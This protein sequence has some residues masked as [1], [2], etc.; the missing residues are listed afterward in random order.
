MKYKTFK[1]IVYS[2]CFLSIFAVNLQSKLYTQ[3]TVAGLNIQ[4]PLALS[5]WIKVNLRYI[6][7]TTRIQ[8]WK[9]PHET[10]LDKGG[11]CEDLATFNYAILKAIGYSPDF[12][13]LRFKNGD[14]IVG[15]AIVT[16]K[17]KAGELWVFDNLNYISTG[18]TS[19]RKFL[20]NYYP[21]TTKYT[22]CKTPGALFCKY[23]KE[24]K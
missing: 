1:W 9:L 24:L 17:D 3:A 4:S 16:F 10:F 19:N 18:V 7:E 8:Y 14:T 22:V 15:H 6:P 11:D 23:N 21:T 5:K 2:I 12:I 13:S 20:L